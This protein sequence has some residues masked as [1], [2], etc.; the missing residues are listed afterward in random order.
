MLD[1][2][3]VGGVTDLQSPIQNCFKGVVER[4]QT[5]IDVERPGVPR[6]SGTIVRF[7]MGRLSANGAQS[8]TRG[9]KVKILNLLETRASNAFQAMEARVPSS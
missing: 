9:T 7:V 8:S 6:G 1:A 2:I 3:P 5:R 4:V